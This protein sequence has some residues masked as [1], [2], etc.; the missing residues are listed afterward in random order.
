MQEVTVELLDVVV[1]IKMYLDGAREEEEGEE[2]GGGEGG[3]EDQDE[4]ENEHRK[5]AS[6][7]RAKSNYYLQFVGW[8]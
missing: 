3:G 1:S 7:L 6:K 8:R 5:S 4:Y 2:G